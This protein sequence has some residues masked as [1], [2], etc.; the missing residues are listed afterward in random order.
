MYH[1]FICI[2]YLILTGT[3]VLSC[4]RILYI[5]IY[6]YIYNIKIRINNVIIRT[7]ILT[8]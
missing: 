6:I 2:Y 7:L 3:Q 5:Y 4:I 1:K 8:I